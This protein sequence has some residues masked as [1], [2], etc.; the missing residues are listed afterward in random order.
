M[1]FNRLLINGLPSSLTHISCSL[2]LWSLKLTI[3]YLYRILYDNS[4]TILSMYVNDIIIIIIMGANTKQFDH[5]PKFL[6]HEHFK[7]NMELLP[8]LFI[9]LFGPLFHFMTYAYLLSNPLCISIIQPSILFCD[10]QS[11]GTFATN[12][13]SR[14]HTKGMELDYHFRGGK[15]CQWF[16]QDFSYVSSS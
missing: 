2:I 13:I 6:L 16:I 11:C 10:N 4:T 8:P 7:L 9:R 3:P 1:T 12:S 5:K 15:G 14:E